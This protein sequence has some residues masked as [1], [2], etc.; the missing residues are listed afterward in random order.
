MNTIKITEHNCLNSA[1][2]W[3]DCQE[4]EEAGET[5][6]MKICVECGKDVGE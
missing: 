2:R 5:C 3:L 1:W 6:E 4:C